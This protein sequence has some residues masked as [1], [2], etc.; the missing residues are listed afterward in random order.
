V[1]NL[2]KFPLE[3]VRKTKSQKE[4]NKL[5][6]KEAKI[7]KENQFIEQITEKFTLNFIQ[8]IQENAVKMGGEPL[9][10]D[11]AIVIES[12]KSLLKRDFGQKH[13]MQN[14]TDTIAKISTL[15]NGKQVTDLSYNKIFISKKAIKPPPLTT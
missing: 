5:G 12:I 6:P 2:I 15:P 10:R 7:I 4:A 1:G 13:P 3:K 14:I 9:L 8:I 11:L